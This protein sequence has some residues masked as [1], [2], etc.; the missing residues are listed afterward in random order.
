MNPINAI[1]TVRTVNSNN[2][3]DQYPHELQELRQDSHMSQFACFARG[4]Q[5]LK[6]IHTLSSQMNY[7]TWKKNVNKNSHDS[8]EC[9]RTHFPYERRTETNYQFDLLIKY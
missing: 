5:L 3:H 4:C 6:L 1:S 9:V 7:T 8:F 2:K